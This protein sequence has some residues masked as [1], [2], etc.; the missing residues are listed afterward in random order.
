MSNLAEYRLALEYE[1]DEMRQRF[2]ASEAIAR[3]LTREL[4][5]ALERM[6]KLVKL[7]REAPHG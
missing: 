2:E 1:R 5:Q 7:L 6:E 3:A 4:D